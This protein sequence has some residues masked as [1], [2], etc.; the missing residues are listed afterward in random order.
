MKNLLIV[1]FLS[2]LS[3][4]FCANS[5]SKSKSK[6]KSSSLRGTAFSQFTASAYIKSRAIATHQ[7][8]VWVCANDEKLY[9]NG[10]FSK[11]ISGTKPAS[12]RKIAT[13]DQSELYVVDKNGDLHYLKKI[14]N[15]NYNWKKTVAKI[16]DVSV[17]INGEV[18]V[19]DTD[20][21]IFEFKGEKL[22]S[23]FSTQKYKGAKSIAVTYDNERIVYVIDS[24]GNVYKQT[25]TAQTKL[26]P[27]ILA[28]EVCV[29]QNSFVFISS[30]LG[31]YMQNPRVN[32]LVLFADGIAKDMDCGNKLWVIGED[33]YIYYNSSSYVKIDSNY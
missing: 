27:N 21:K 25:A 16:T 24:T 8:N 26:H 12:C 13:N 22:G 10:G 31:I 20:G 33:G 2:F 14:N 28:D 9:R 7:D 19:I 29:N 18:F 11:G 30:G 1:L 3:M 4:F 6:S 5:L 32:E 23:Q 15:D 17:G